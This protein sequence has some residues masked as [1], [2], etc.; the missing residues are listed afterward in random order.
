MNLANLGMITGHIGSPERRREPHARP[1]QRAGLLRHGR[2]AQLVPRLPERARL[3]A[4]EA[5]FARGLRRADAARRSACASPRCSTPPCDGKLKAMYIM[6]EDPALTDA[7]ANHVRKALEQPRL[8]RRPE[9]LH[10]RDGQVRRRLPAG[11]AATRRRTARSPTPSAACSA[12]ARRSSRRAS[13]A[14]DWEIILRP[15]Q[16]ARLPDAAST[17]PRRSSRR[18]AAWCRSSPASP[19]SASRTQGL[20][21]PC[22]TDGPSRHAVPARGQVHARQG[23]AA[24]HPV[25]AAGGA[26]RRRVPDAAHHRAACSTTTTS[27]RASPQSLEML[28]PHELAEVNPADAERHGVSRTS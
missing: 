4:P 14:P 1:E 12:C 21:W 10:D 16:A 11:G 28:R 19:T 25:P 2:P 22:P 6:G 15:R 17:R 27:S 9:H 8:P 24:G 20:Q 7:D 3:E 5:K 13:A 26:R 23:P 18:S